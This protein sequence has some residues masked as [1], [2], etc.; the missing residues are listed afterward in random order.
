MLA[1]RVSVDL[2]ARP[3]GEN[4]ALVLQALFCEEL[5]REE[6]DDGEGGLR[7]VHFLAIE[8]D[9]TDRCARGAVAGQAQ[10]VGV[11]AGQACGVTEVVRS[12]L[13]IYSTADFPAG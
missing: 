10:P 13:T 1:V 9:G 12:V 6:Y 2:V 8:M 5:F 11:V 3:F 7:A 4:A